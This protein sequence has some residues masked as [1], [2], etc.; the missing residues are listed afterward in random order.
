MSTYQAPQAASVEDRLAILEAVSRQNNVRFSALTE[1][2]SMDET[3][4][5]EALT[6]LRNADLV[7]T[8]PLR[9]EDDSIVASL[10]RLRAQERT[11]LHRLLYT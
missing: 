4:A 3:V 6:D 5:Y 2:L 8:C 7:S 11:K 1:R 9:G 10:P